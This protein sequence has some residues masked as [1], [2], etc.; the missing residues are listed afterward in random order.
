MS[1]LQS[2]RGD[3]VT[4][5][6]TVT[7]SDGAPLDLTGADIT[8]TARRTINGP[9]FVVKTLDDGID[10][11]GSGETGV[12]TVTIAPEDTDTL[13]HTERFVW[14]IQVDDGLDVRTPLRGRWVVSMD[15][16]HAEGSGS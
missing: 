12:C 8:F 14:D 6:F 1:L 15:V 10:L 5:T 11:G 4:F 16:T 9:A 7:D 2:I 13:T 3:T